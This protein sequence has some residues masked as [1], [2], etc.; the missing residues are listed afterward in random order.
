M[1]NH[2]KQDKDGGQLQMR[3]RASAGFTLIEVTISIV[4]A[5]LVFGGILTGYIQSAKRAEWSGYSLSAQAYG[6][7]QLEQARAATWDLSSTITTN[8]LLNLNSNNNMIGWTYSAGTYKGYSWT[9]IDIPYS[10][11]NY[12]RA[13]NFVTLTTNLVVSVAAGVDVAVQMLQVDTVW[14]FKGKNYTNRMVNY[15]APDQ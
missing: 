8:Q 9:N 12:M 13:T 11:T 14:R 1:R 6:V 3:R 4:I 10:G 5:A 7:Q 15:Y 2:F